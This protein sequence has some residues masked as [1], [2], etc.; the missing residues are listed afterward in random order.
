MGKPDRGVA[1]EPTPTDA[2]L[3]RDVRRARSK[4]LVGHG[5]MYVVAC[6]FVAEWVTVLGAGAAMMRGLSSVRSSTC[7]PATGCIAALLK[8]C[9]RD[10]TDYHAVGGGR[11]CAD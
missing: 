1:P 5:E 2:E 8:T 7:R 6:G 3:E 4:V 9:M 10:G 11:R